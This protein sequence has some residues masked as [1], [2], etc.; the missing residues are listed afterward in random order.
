MLILNNVGMTYHSGS[1]PVE[2]LRDVNLEINDG[3]FVSLL[4]P[5]GCGKST[6]LF[7]VT[8]LTVPTAGYVTIDD[9]KIT[10]P[11]HEAGFVFQDHLLLEWRNVLQN[12][13]IQGELRGMD[14]QV[15]HERS[16][17]LLH[18]VGLEDFKDKYPH[19]LSGGMQQRISI[20]R[21]LHHDPKL[22]LMD[23]PFGA[24]DAFT[25]DQMRVDLERLWAKRNSTVLFV[26]H[27]IS[28]AIL[29]SDRV[30]VISRRPGTVLEQI[31]IDLPRPRNF[32][33]SESAE[34]LSYKHRLTKTF[35]EMG[36]L[37]E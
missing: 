32:S 29:L 3:E 23:E 14:K 10:E 20:C 24:L 18:M 19:E 13:S 33:V 4:G 9:K 5:S 27:D 8:G 37:Y 15:A 31:K 11:F 26:T 17:E 28:E 35:M 22:L 1:G 7:I 25:R 12:V 30:V 36:V 16:M 6:L 21:A 2:A 34:F